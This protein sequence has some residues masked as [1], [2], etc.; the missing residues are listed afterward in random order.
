MSN[1]QVLI[2]DPLAPYR[3]HQKASIPSKCFVSVGFPGKNGR[4]IYE[5]V[6]VVIKQGETVTA[7]AKRFRK[8]VADEL[9]SKRNKKR[10]CKP[11]GLF[12]LIY[13][14]P[15]DYIPGIFSENAPSKF[16]H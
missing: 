4:A 9:N 1:I 16:L 6:L 12:F 15:Q 8:T 14:T 5:K 2:D 3:V 13:S 10:D 11:S 7:A